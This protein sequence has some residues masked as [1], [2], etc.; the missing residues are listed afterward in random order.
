MKL[1]ISST[2]LDDLERV[3]KRLI[4]ACIPCA[5]CK[6]PRSSHLSV[7]IQQD[8][9]F[10]LA[11]SVVMNRDRRSRLPHWARAFESALPATMLPRL[12]APMEQSRREGCFSNQR[13]R[14][15]QARQARQTLGAWGK[16][17]GQLD[18][19]SGHGPVLP[20]STIRQR[21]I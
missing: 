15:A 1:L 4:W 20:Q 12:P 9:D 11:L 3:V 21:I 14:L 6:E 17:L 7:W 19:R 2:D 10:P 8:L 5:V 16:R 18:Q 13:R